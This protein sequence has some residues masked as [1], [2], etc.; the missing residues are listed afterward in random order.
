MSTAFPGEKEACL[1]RLVVLLQQ[2]NLVLYDLNS[3]F[4]KRLDLALLRVKI[5]LAP[6]V[7]GTAGGQQ[8][9]QKTGA[10]S[11]TGAH[12]GTN[13]QGASKSSG[14]T[15]NSQDPEVM[16]WA[17]L[18]PIERR[19]LLDGPIFAGNMLSVVRG[20]TAYPRLL[21]ALREHDLSKAGFQL[22]DAF[23]VVCLEEVLKRAGNTVSCAFKPRTIFD[24]L[25][26]F[27]VAGYRKLAE[28]RRYETARNESQ[29]RHEAEEQKSRE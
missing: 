18:L 29:R 19:R 21:S 14:Q 12:S 4:P 5:G 27:C 28:Q 7:A 16:L 26:G 23:I 13:G 20:T 10:A 15:F 3:Q 24:D 8:A 9:G 22:G 1:Q 11:G 25:V 17:H 2:H 6:M